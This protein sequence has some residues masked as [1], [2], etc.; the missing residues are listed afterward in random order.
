MSDF[1]KIILMGR[2]TIK[3]ELRYTPSGAAVATLRMA[4]SE[5]FKTKSGEEKER[6]IFIDANVW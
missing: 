2:L 4:S 1:N 5:R 3:P 6:T